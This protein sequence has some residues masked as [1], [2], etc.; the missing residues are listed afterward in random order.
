MENV[1]QKILFIITKSE[2]GGAQR[3]ILDTSVSLAKQ[4][5]EVLVAAGGNGPLL[6]RVKFQ[7]PDV[8]TFTLKRLKRTPG[9]INAF[10]GILEIYKL[11]KEEK[12]D[13]LFLNSTA[14]GILGSIANHFYK[15]SRV[16]YRIGGW[17]FRDPRP[18]WQNKIILWLEKYTA[19]FKD[20]IIVNCEIDRELAIKHRIA[21]SEKILKIYNGLD[22]EKLEFLPKAMARQKLLS[23]K[24][25][26]NDI[27]SSTIVGCVA[28]FYKTKGLKYLI[29][30]VRL[31]NVKTVIIGDGPLRPELERLIKEYNLENQIILTGRI[32][33]AY[34]YLKAF[35]V[36]VLPSLKEGFPWIILEAMASE[37]PIIATNV[38]ALPEIIE[39]GKEGLLI[40]IKNSQKLAEKIAYIIEHPEKSQEM[41]ALA[42][43]KLIQQFT[44]QKML[45]KTKQLLT[46]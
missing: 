45:E 26:K 40:D 7:A 23:R 27:D 22:V 25:S 17:A 21:P 4:G 14:A 29:E 20:E 9:P 37:T 6:K 12:P 44:L 30:A 31:V 32:P 46:I 5:Y 2:L 13:I 11:L 43:Q 38:G 15:K 16:I 39:H 41:T 19:R 10:L 36:F 18:K 33:D 24:L 1:K 34:K 28:N 42:K 35:D 3:Y 8:K